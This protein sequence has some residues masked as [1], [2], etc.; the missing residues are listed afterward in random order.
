MS[1]TLCELIIYAC[2]TGPLAEQLEYFFHRSR[3]ELGP[4]T[5]HRYMP[6]CSLT[7]FFHDVAGA[8]PF[9]VDELEK[10][11]TNARASQPNTVLQVSAMVLSDM[12]KYL[13]LESEWLLLLMRDFAA[14]ST[15]V[16]RTDELRLK[17]WLHLSLAYDHPPEQEMTLSLLAKNS[18]DPTSPVGWNLCLYERRPGDNWIL[19]AQWRLA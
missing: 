9:Y 11:L 1:E 6:H 14:H 19:H 7:G 16:T 13:K 5:A 18:I 8:I 12:F 15:S 3:S 2:P 17:G 4:N 10:T